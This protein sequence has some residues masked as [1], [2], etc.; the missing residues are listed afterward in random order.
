MN[1]SS[2]CTQV[3]WRFC[4]AVCVASHVVVAAATLAN[5]YSFTADAVDSVGGKNGVLVNSPEL[6]DGNVY[7]DGGY[8]Q[9]VDL[10]ND[11]IADRL[12]ITIEAW[13][14]PSLNSSWARIWDFGNSN[15]G[16]DQSDYGTKH[17]MCYLLPNLEATIYAGG[18]DSWV[19]SS[20]ARTL[21]QD[22]ESHVVWTSDGT[23]QR[24]R[25]YVNG[26]LVGKND[27][28]A[29]TPVKLGATFNNWLGRSQFSPDPYFSGA[30][31]EF[32]IWDG[33]L[34]A[35]EV[36]AS[37]RS[38]PDTVSTDPGSLTS[39]VLEVSYQMV[40]GNVQ[41]ARV[42]ATTSKVPDAVNIA[43]IP[44]IAYASGDTNILT[45]SAAGSVRAVA[46]GTTTLTATYQDRS[47]AATITVIEQPAVLTHR[48]SFT[49]NA[50]DSVGT[51]HG[52]L[53]GGAVIDGGQ[54]VLD[55][56]AESYVELPSG[57]ITDYQALTIETWATFGQLAT[58]SRL[59][60]F[61]DQNDAGQGR[62][63][64]EL[65]PHGGSADTY[66]SI[67]DADPGG[68][69]ADAVAQ[70]APLDNQT[71]VH[72]VA[73]FN[74][75][76]GY[77]A[78]YVNGNLTGRNSSPG[79]TL[80]GVHDVMNWIGRSLFSADPYLNGS[81]DEFRIYRGALSSLEVAVSH[82]Y[83]PGSTTR[84]AGALVSIT[85]QIPSTMTAESGVAPTV[86]ATYASLTNFDLT[87]NSLGTVAGLTYTTSDPGVLFLGADGLIH[88]GKL[89]SAT[90]TASYQGKTSSAVVAV[91]PPAAATLRHRYSFTDVNDSVGDAHGV[92]VG[93]AKVAGGKLVLDG[94]PDTFLD[95]PGGL[96]SSL[97]A[98]TIEFWAD[99]GS[100]PNWPRVFDF[101]AISGTSGANFLFFTPKTHFGAHRFGI[102][103]GAGAS[104]LDSA[105]VFENSSLHVACVYDPTS[106]F[107]G[108]YTNGVLE[109]ATYNVRIPLD[110][111]A[112]DYGFIGRS[113]FS[114]DGY[115]NA[116]LD[117]FRIWEGRLTGEQLA[118]N[119]RSGPDELA[120]PVLTAG[121]EGGNLVLAWPVSASGYTL[122]SS[123]TLG[124]NASWSAAGGN[125][126]SEGGFYR[127]TL[128]LTSTT[129]F[130]LRR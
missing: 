129:F 103:T 55:P 54:V 90:V 100:Q 1:S 45:V 71:N 107:Q 88:S 119:Y 113:L 124:P 98:V 25:L 108:I 101:G 70:A 65:C 21:P 115:L 43:D 64:V 22:E 112:A 20:P 6:F 77:H 78:L 46:A 47:D 38:G 56:L 14:T 80:A 117:E 28:A 63:Y 61:G 35:L 60:S 92:L 97:D 83:G 96:V 87:A 7:L 81:V 109:V 104:D 40:K 16:E 29:N 62:Y 41:Q 118:A 91:T 93:A 48:Y 27:A 99:F 52:T 51:A 82:A 127:V 102:A 24:A 44:G 123:A 67:S 95:L 85:L 84:N 32:R 120:G 17:F 111:V 36:V 68:N 74:P 128:P 50:N 33:A 126:V 105:S 12:S 10:P 114:A 130:R 49:A 122:E 75:L 8:Q 69:H 9:Y 53:L 121:L 73:V 116:S 34:T 26:V 31:N 37:G 89:G 94:S 110:A 15:A 58:W 5:R 30:F 3:V 57:V 23:A 42:L 4:G 59:W 13:I 76:A 11:L 86:L 125:V 72:V 66:V 19:R 18:S 39:L 2:A 79:V 106:G